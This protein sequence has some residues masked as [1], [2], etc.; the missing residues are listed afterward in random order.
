MPYYVFQSEY[1]GRTLRMTIGRTD[2][3]NIPDAENKAKAD[4]FIASLSIIG[5]AGAYADAEIT[6]GAYVDAIVTGSLPVLPRRTF[7]S[8]R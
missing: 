2:A 5:V 4:A 1:Q 6:K 7:T 3:W 8:P